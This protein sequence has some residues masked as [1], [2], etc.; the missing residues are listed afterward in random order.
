[1]CHVLQF[2]NSVAIEPELSLAEIRV[3]SHARRDVR[4]GVCVLEVGNIFRVLFVRA[5]ERGIFVSF[6]LVHYVSHL[7]ERTWGTTKLFRSWGRH[8]RS[9]HPPEER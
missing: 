7:R 4:G 8:C 5:F 9:S 6:T 3:S 1:M 2:F